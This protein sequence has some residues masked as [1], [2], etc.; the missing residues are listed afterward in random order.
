MKWYWPE[1]TNLEESEKA[2]HEGAGVCFV[3][4]GGA[5]II[6][7]MSLWLGKPV[8]GWTLESSLTEES[9]Q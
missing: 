8:I 9:L 6:G 5:A 3:V 4:A 7:A 1:L 2:A